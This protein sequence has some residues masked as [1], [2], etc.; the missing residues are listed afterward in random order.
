[1]GGEIIELK[2]DQLLAIERH[3]ASTSERL[4]A[5]E[6][7]QVNFQQEQIRMWR[8]YADH[9]KD[10]NAQRELTDHKDHHPK[11]NGEFKG[12]LTQVRIQWWF[13]AAI[14]LMLIG[15]AY[16]AVKLWPGA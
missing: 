9:Q 11:L 10:C 16:A 13:I 2:I 6:I 15:G 3:M 12:I 7:N 5:I 8:V 14:F 1:M 4:K